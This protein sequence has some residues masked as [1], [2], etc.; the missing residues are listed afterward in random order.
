MAFKP[1]VMK[2]V[3]LILGDEATG[4]NF[5]CQLRSVKLTPDTNVVKTK[6]LCPEGQYADVEDPEW[7]LE[8][9]YL[10]GEGDETVQALADFLLDHKGE[11]EDFY[12]RPRAGG[13]GYSG[14]VTLMA[15]GIG[16]E[17][18]GFS[19]QS[20]QLPL[21]GQPVKVAAVVTP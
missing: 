4:P 19:E 9:G 10:T 13:P 18:G 21:D 6:T 15:G 1:I 3:D 8:L 7:N 12:F 11:K 16:G 20:V 14:V 17:Q 5:K 2:N